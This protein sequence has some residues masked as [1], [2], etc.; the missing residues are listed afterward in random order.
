[1]VK[2]NFNTIAANGAWQVGSDGNSI[3][4]MFGAII[5]AANKIGAVTDTD[6]MR[7]TAP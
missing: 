1:M 6:A 7:L 2:F 4:Q 5:A 3:S